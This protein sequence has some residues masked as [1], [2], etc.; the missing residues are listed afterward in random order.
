MDIIKAIIFGIVEGLT[1]FLPVSSTGHLILVGRLLPMEPASFKNAFDI[2]IQLGAILA[3]VVL[4][5]KRLNPIKKIDGKWR[6]SS[7]KMQ[8]WSK[9]IVGCIPAAV[10][11]LLFDDFIDR[12]LFNPQVVTVTLLLYG[13]IIILME[14]RYKGSDRYEAVGDIS[15]ATAFKIGLFQCLAMI[16]GTSRSAATIIGARVLGAGRVA[17]AE[18]SF[19]LA[20]P[21]MI[22]ATLLKVVKLGGILTSYQWFLIGV[23]FVVSFFVALM[24]V[25]A[26]MGYIKQHSFKPF[27]VYRIILSLVLIVAMAA[28]VF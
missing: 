25:N 20:I 3:I 10:L 11:G 17:A 23:G 14:T 12:Y 7:K 1:E 5:R 21:T 18:F 16:P 8:L 22:G 24:V 27:G 4:Y 15:Y 9:I 26:F 19:F 13:V 6:V 28:G 2:I